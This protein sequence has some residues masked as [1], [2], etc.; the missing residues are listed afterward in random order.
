MRLDRSITRMARALV[1]VVLLALPVVTAWNLIAAPLNPR[2]L[3]IIGQRLG[4]VTERLPVVWSWAALRDGSL[5]K[6]L[7]LRVEEA[8]PLRPLLIRSYNQI[9][10]T[11]FDELTAPLLV[12]GADRQLIEQFYIDDYCNRTIEMA[13]ARAAKMLPLLQ[14]IQAHYRARGALFFYVVT[15]TKVGYMPE[16]F[17]GVQ[18]CPSTQQARD[19]LRP[20]YLKLLQDGG[21]DV[22]DAAA[23]VYAAKSDTPVPLFLRNGEHWNDLGIAIGTSAV[24]NKLN[25]LAG[26]EIA[27]P[28]TYSYSVDLLTTGRDNDLANLQSQLLSPPSVPT[29]HV[30]YTPSADC[31]H[32]PARDIEAA[33]V[34][35]SFIRLSAEVMIRHACLSKLSFYFY[36]HQLREAGP[37]FRVMEQ[38]L[39]AQRLSALRDVRVMILEENEAFMGLSGHV[40]GLHQVLFGGR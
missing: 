12:R 18:A 28:P 30:R 23:P 25:Q 37:S 15:P 29:P 11:L 5:Q 14:D 33:V 7:A 17:V 32:H 34:G 24:V 39:T 38:N 31:G 27:P 36:L 19:E 16:A 13:Q 3:A 35:S 26:R 9:R 21:I 22:L 4:G 10:S 6:A 1:Y 40:A 8:N 20:R 2:L